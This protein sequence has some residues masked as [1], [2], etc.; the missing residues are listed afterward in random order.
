MKPPEE[1]RARTRAA[2][3]DLAREIR[4]WSVDELEPLAEAGLESGEVTEDEVL[5]TVSDHLMPIL[6]AAFLLQLED[7]AEDIGVAADAPDAIREAEEAADTLVRQLAPRA[8]EAIR[9]V[10]KQAF[11]ADWGVTRTARALQKLITLTP[12]QVVSV[13]RYEAELIKD[14]AKA[15]KR[16]ARDR[17]FDRPLRRGELPTKAKRDRMVERY[18]SALEKRRALTIAREELWQAQQLAEHALWQEA[19]ATNVFPAGQVRKFWNDREDSHVRHSHSGISDK[20]PDGIGLDEAFVTGLGRLRYPLDP[21]GVAADRIGCRCWLTFKVV[22][23]AG[24]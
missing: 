5:K 2:E 3:R 6:A 4:T 11:D 16:N 9:D 7:V 18:R 12:Q 23:E 21:R 13:Q 8:H 19:V 24:T 1:L 20:Y 15:L 10:V 22:T 14:P 17:R